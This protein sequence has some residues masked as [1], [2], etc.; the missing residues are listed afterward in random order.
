MTTSLLPNTICH[1][2]ART[3]Y[4]I[5]ARSTATVKS[6]CNNPQGITSLAYLYRATLC[7]R[8]FT[9]LPVQC[10]VSLKSGP[11]T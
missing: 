5:L 9:L 11:E 6:P 10:I 7:H 3:T 2:A 1:P 4:F 8:H